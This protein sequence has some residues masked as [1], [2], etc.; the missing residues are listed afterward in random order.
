MNILK[1]F[2]ITVHIIL[3]LIFIFI[4]NSP[5]NI[6]YKV[7]TP[8]TFWPDYSVFRIVAETLSGIGIG[9]LSIVGAIGFKKDKQLA[10]YAL[11]LVFLLLVIKI[12]FGVM[13]AAPQGE[14]WGL[15]GIALIFAFILFVIFVLESIYMAMLGKKKHSN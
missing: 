15:G 13:S 10:M 8:E 11:P 7:N 2:I 5:M 6:Y 12:V 9:L 4:I 3:G 14:D 1:I